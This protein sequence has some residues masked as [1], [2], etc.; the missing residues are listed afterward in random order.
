MRHTTTSGDLAAR[1]LRVQRLAGPPFPDARAAVA[2]LGAVQAQ[3]YLGSLWALG[4]RSRARVEAD[5]ERLIAERSIVRTWPMRG[6]L[7]L[8]AAADARWMLELLTPPVVVRAAARLRSI[9]LDDAVFRRSRKAL[10]DRLRGGR[11]LTRSA[12]YDVLAAAGIST[13]GQRGIHILWRLAQ[14]RVLCF[15][16]RD[17]K[18]QT[19]ALFDEWLP[20]ARSLPRDE[21]LA[22]I[23][24]RYFR[25]HGPATLRDF[26]WWSGLPA[27][28]ARE[29]LE[30]ARPRLA[31]EVAAG[32]ELWR[33]AAARPRGTAAARPRLLPAF[34][35]L[36]VGYKERSPVLDPSHAKRVPGLLSPT[37]LVDGRVVGTWTRSLGPGDAVIVRASWFERGGRR[38]HADAFAAAAA[39]YARFVGRRLVVR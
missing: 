17:G 39:D 4:L 31:R 22:E 29:A 18:Q 6:T 14:E 2:A 16:G 32:R 12:A 36:L 5:V 34:D 3:D 35:E 21:A 26:A 19:F 15:A 33:S 10:E 11:R 27:A 20:E 37:I 13:A 25:G 30:L 23:A 8:V 38:A 24:A 28:A 1:R 9:G 7:H